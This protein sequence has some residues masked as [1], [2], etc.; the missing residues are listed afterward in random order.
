MNSEVGTA[1]N[2]YDFSVVIPIY[3]EAGN[4][5][6]LDKELQEVL[7]GLSTNF[8]VIYI[9]DGSRDSSLAELKSLKKVRII[10]LNRNYGQATA[11]DAGFKAAQGKII[12]SM[13]GDG[14]NDPHDIPTLIKE[15][16]EKDLDVVA[17]WR[18]DR[19]DKQGIKILTRIGRIFRGLLMADVVHDSGCAL[20]VYRKVA[21]K[22][23]DIGGEMHRYILALLRWKG[24]TIGELVVN[25]RP[26]LHGKS[27]YN[28]T[29]ALRGFFDL[30]YIWF[31]HKYSQRPLH[32]FGY[33]SLSLF[34]VSIFAG[35]LSV[36]EKINIG[37]SLN[38]NGW[39]FIAIFL[40]LGSTL[41]FSFGIV[42]DLLVRL[43][44]NNY[45][46][47]KRYYVRDVIET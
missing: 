28:Y 9:N 46:Y 15:L 41:F 17:G 44:L 37:L 24:F 22:S 38:R 16:Q 12:I 20:R 43:H 47:E 29:K 23:L 32:L 27:H 11:F 18:K 33:V 42:I 5:I 4:I 10:N 45:P 7:R 13:D 14:Q 34:I 30:I 26:R 40:F 8:E 2:E 39:F 1:M 25:D 35:I 3:N 36:Y 19:K 31:I 6:S 21:V